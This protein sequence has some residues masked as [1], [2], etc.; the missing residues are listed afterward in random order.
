M[1]PS[2]EE[3]DRRLGLVEGEVHR[4]GGELRANTVLT[5]QVAAA[6]TEIAKDTAEIVEIFKEARGA[7]RL[8]D[9]VMHGA[10]YI[11]TVVLP[12]VTLCG[13]LYFLVTGRPSSWVEALR[14]IVK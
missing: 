2:L 12:V 4:L 6:Q 11:V 9:R 8:F 3:L 14:V 7:F 1:H 10:R 5:Q 13:A